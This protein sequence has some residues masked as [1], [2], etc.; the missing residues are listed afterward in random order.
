MK[1]VM[2]IDGD[3]GGQFCTMKRIYTTKDLRKAVS[4]ADEHW[5]YKCGQ[6]R[7]TRW[8]ERT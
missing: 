3:D 8:S 6:G 5:R 7:D 4:S 1:R 2:R